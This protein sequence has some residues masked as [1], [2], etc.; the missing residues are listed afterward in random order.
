MAAEPAAW[1][2]DLV[3]ACYLFFFYY[4]VGGLL[5]YFIKNLN[6]EF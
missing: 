6:F 5:Y 2:T 3:M 1:V 4:L